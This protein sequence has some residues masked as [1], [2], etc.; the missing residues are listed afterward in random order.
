MF[1]K[2]FLPICVALVIFAA[3]IGK[4]LF[5]QKLNA[6]IRLNQVGFYPQAP[7]LAV[8]VGEKSTDFVVRDAAGKA[9]FK[10]KLSEIRNNQHSGKVS[11]IADFS[12]VKKAGKYT[13]EVPGLGKSAAFDVKPK[14]HREVA[15]ASLKGFY[16]QRVSTDL[17]EKFAGKWARPAG[18]PDD[19]VLI[20]ASAVS[21]GRPEN[22]V[23]SS[24]KGWYDAGDYNKYIVN[25]GIT[26]GTLL[27]LYEDFPLYFEN[28]NTNIPE[29]NNSIPDLLDEVIWNLRWML[30]MQDPADGG[31]YHKLTNPRFDGMIMPDAA[32][33][34][35]YVVQKN[36]VATLDF[37]AVMAQAGR[38]LK[39]FENKLPGLS[40]SCIVAAV[41]GW[42][43]AA[44]HPEVYYDQNE[45]NKKF[46]PDIVSG[47]YG[48]RSVADERI[49]AAAEMYATTGKTEYLKGIDLKAKQP[50]ALPTWSM[51]QT[52]GYYTLIRTSENLKTEAALI[53]PIK[54]SVKDYADGLLVDLAKQPYHTVMGKIAKDYSW[55][56]SS[57]AANQ[58]IALLYAFKLTKDK[59]YLNAALGNLDYLLGRNATTYCFLTGFGSKRVMHPHHRPSVA[60]GIEDPV[61]GL[62]SGG[63]N[64]GHQDKCK[65]YTNNFADESF[66][67]DDCSYASNEIAINWN[68]PMVYLSAAIE[69]IMEQ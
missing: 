50:L 31:V 48:D 56:S 68:A 69:A 29:N 16:Y 52:L 42:E 51:V 26:M 13:L 28:F 7:K 30:T 59:K 57:V 54:K 37:V 62:L 24:P 44:K 25:S 10:G 60:D 9:V 34:P 36:T 1:K 65:T 22:F 66:T 39:S 3:Q 32:D 64:P 55:G 14:V 46:D 8:V 18:H 63:P 15:A 6:D 4:P 58:G 40:D 19:K 27:S 2:S 41:K 43:W 20:H 21:E 38:I 61:P 53:D 67:D 11:R 23:I 17:P 47:A 33:K 35:R 45:I 49:W 5:A 12:S